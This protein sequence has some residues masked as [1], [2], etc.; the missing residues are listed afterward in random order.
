MDFNIEG[1]FSKICGIPR[2]E[3][4]KYEK[5]LTAIVRSVEITAVKDDFLQNL[6]VKIGSVI[7]SKNKKPHFI[8]I[9][10]RDLEDKPERYKAFFFCQDIYSRAF[11][12]YDSKLKDEKTKW[13]LIARE[14]GAIMNERLLK[15]KDLKTINYLFAYIVLERVINYGIF[16]SDKE[17]FNKIIFFCN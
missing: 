1:E 9:M 13:I 5:F 16:I 6:A 3:I 12:Y 15:R 11:I 4:R 14:I 17:L 10:E 2:E 7:D 8:N